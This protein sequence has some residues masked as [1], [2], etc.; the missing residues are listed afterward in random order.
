MLETGDISGV[1]KWNKTDALNQPWMVQGRPSRCSTENF[2]RINRKGPQLLT[3]LYLPHYGIRAPIGTWSRYVGLDNVFPA[4]RWK[5]LPMSVSGMRLYTCA[6]HSTSNIMCLRMVVNE[7]SIT[8]PAART[9]VVRTIPLASS[10]HR[11]PKHRMSRKRPHALLKRQYR[12]E[13]RETAMMMTV[14]GGQRRKRY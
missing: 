13:R 4:R 6:R 12:K 5:K 9:L 7:P 1:T 3:A 14:G 8:A 11:K 2:Q 10:H